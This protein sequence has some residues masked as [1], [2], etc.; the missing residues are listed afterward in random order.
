M[1][2]KISRKILP[3]FLLAAILVIV[4]GFSD[5][6]VASAEMNSMDNNITLNQTM[7]SVNTVNVIIHQDET[8]DNNAL[9]PCCENKQGGA[10]AI[11]ASTFNQNIKFSSLGTE[12]VIDPNYIFQ[13][14]L[15]ELS[16]ASPPK[17][18]IISSVFLKE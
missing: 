3:S 4:G 10:S 16:S 11:Q 14:K 9:K 2:K 15:I 7:H 1:I 12:T 5:G 13:Y 17:P 18:D 8:T 6:M